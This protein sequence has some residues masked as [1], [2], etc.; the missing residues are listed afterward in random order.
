MKKLGVNLIL[1]TALCSVVADSY[2]VRSYIT[3][4]SITQVRVYGDGRFG[5]CTAV[6]NVNVNNDGDQSLT[7]GK[8][9]QVSFDCLG[10]RG[11][12]RST[13][14]N[15]FNIAQLAYVTGKVIDLYVDDTDQLSGSM[16]FSNFIVARD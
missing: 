10:D 3:G 2:A 7:C 9:S 8:A 5:E 16:C 12:S 15:A 6:L 1:L 11:T 13:A 4:A 14:Q